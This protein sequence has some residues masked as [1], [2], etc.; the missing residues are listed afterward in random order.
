LAAGQAAVI[1]GT[2]TPEPPNSAG[3]SFIFGNPSL[4]GRTVSA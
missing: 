2:K 4:I 3:K 1:S